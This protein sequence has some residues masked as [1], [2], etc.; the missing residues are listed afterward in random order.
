MVWVAPTIRTHLEKVKDRVINHDADFV[1][2][3]DGEEGSGKSVLAQ[4][5]ASVLDP[6]FNIDKIAFNAEEFMNLVRNPERKAGDC[7]ILDEA[8]AGLNARQSLSKIN[9]AVV[10]LATEMR[11]LN[12][13][14]IIVLPSFFDLDR[15]FALWRCRALFHVYIDKEGRRGQYKVWKKKEKENL[16]LLGKKLYNYHAWRPKWRPFNFPK[17]Y[18]VDEKEYRSRK[19]KAFQ[20]G[21]FDLE[22]KIPYK[23]RKMLESY[24]QNIEKE[25]KEVKGK[26]L[27][28]IFGLPRSSAF[29]FLKEYRENPSPR[30]QHNNTSPLKIDRLS[31]NLP[32]IEEIEENDEEN[33]EF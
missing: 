17:G 14:C 9:R 24:I 32:K 19:I 33:T 2:V 21:G 29:R 25:G 6:N 13:F 10:G 22:P 16:Y 3:L 31:L 4:Q 7:I 20:A 18:V 30:V 23:S 26:D 15:Y 27:M 5:L 28:D 1:I 8:F 12:L 11:Q